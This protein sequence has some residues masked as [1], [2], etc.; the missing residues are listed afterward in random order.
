MA[1]EPKQVI[2]IPELDN[3]QGAAQLEV[4]TRKYSNGQIVSAAHVQ[5]AKDGMVTFM[6]YGDFRW[7][8]LC[9]TGRATQ[10]ILD[11]Q[12]ATAFNPDELGRIKAEAIAFYAAKRKQEAA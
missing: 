6:L 3:E 8:A 11:H 9:T 7:T 2:P 1:Q 5:F 12:H 10:K 4:S